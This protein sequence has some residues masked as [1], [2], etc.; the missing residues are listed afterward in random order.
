MTDLLSTLA[1]ATGGL[2]G[3]VRRPRPQSVKPKLLVHLVQA[4]PET[5]ESLSDKWAALL[6]N[7]ADPAQRAKV[8]PSFITILRDL[9]ALD[10]HVLQTIA[11]ASQGEAAE[12]RPYL[13]SHA[14]RVQRE[15]GEGDGPPTSAFG[16]AVDNLMRLGLCEGRG[17]TRLLGQPNNTLAIL[18]GG[19]SDTLAE[20]PGKDRFA[21]TDLDLAFLAACTPPTA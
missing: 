13:Y 2:S 20:G 16:I 3:Q 18:I 1:L 6:A 21:I 11:T 15:V 5:D 9:S 12:M 4:A 17:T 19:H 8:Q 7:A 14:T 10:A